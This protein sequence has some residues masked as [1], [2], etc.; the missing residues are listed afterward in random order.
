MMAD[1]GKYTVDEAYFNRVETIM[2]YALNEDM[3]VIINIHFDGGWWA[4][5]GSKDQAKRKEAMKKFE[6]MW[7]Q[8]STRFEEYSDHL[9]LESANEE[10]GA[11]LNSTDDYAGSGYFTSQDQLFQQT[12]AINQAFVNVVRSTGGNNQKRFLLIAGYDT[13]IGLTSDDRYKMPED[14]IGGRLIVSV[15]YY[16]PAP[17]CIANDPENCWGY[18]DTWGTNQ[19]IADMKSEI[20]TMRI[21]F[22]NK[23]YP[24]IIGEYGV[25]DTKIAEN[26]FEKKKGRDLFFKTLCELA[27]A[28]N[29]CPMLWDTSQVFDRRTCTML[30]AADRENYLTL[31]QKIREK[32]VAKPN[33][34]K[35]LARWSGTLSYSGWYQTVVEGENWTYPDGDAGLI[36]SRDL[37]KGKETVVDLSGGKLSGTQRLFL[38]LGVENIEADFMITVRSGK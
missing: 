35:R 4:R 37:K 3:Y 24:V 38:T 7:L 30:D 10:L 13:N 6:N 28:N 14:N 2:N 34:V 5:F 19:D 1:D 27:A 12:N 18:S 8:I 25:C 17:Y 9:I 16:A 11:R 32:P 36:V 22:V 20:A 31:S 23:G 21:H 29:M 26:K 15:H 33:V